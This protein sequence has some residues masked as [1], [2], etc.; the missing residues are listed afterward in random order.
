MSEQDQ[1]PELAEYKYTVNGMEHTAMFTEDEAEQYPDAEKVGD[2]GGATEPRRP[3]QMGLGVE[4]RD[5]AAKGDRAEK[6]RPVGSPDPAASSKVRN[7][8]DK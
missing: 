7:A 4:D 3:Q 5:Q 8:R 2:G 6:A 1:A